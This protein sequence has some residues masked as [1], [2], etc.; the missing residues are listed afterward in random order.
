MGLFSEEFK[1]HLVSEIK[2]IESVS[3]VEVVIVVAKSSASYIHLNL[4]GGIFFSYLTLTYTM[5]SDYE[6]SDEVLYFSII[7][8]FFI[9]FLILYIPFLARLLVKRETLIRNVE[10]YGRALFQKGKIY[11]TQ[12]RQGIL[13]YLSNFERRVL[14]LEDKNVSLRIPIHELKLIK[15]NFN[16]I[17]HPFSQTKTTENFLREL[18]KFKD[19]CAKFIP[20]T[21]ND[22]NE[23]PDDMEIIL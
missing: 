22:V 2:K 6:F 17:F 16:H 12:S 9:G 4:L 7:I 1:K 13:I 11:E 21:K 5:F 23:L 8:A 3:G 15:T 18:N 20:V 19:L 10:I 14:V